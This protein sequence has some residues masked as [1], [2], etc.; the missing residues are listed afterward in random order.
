MVPPTP[1]CSQ[2]WAREKASATS[3][4]SP[5]SEPRFPPEIP[6]AQHRAKPVLWNTVAQYRV[7]KLFWPEVESNYTFY[8]GGSTEQ[9]EKAAGFRHPGHHHR[10]V[11]PAIPPIPNRVPASPLVPA[12]KSLPQRFRLH[13][14][15][16]AGYDRALDLL[17][18]T[19]PPQAE[20]TMPGS[21]PAFLF[22]HPQIK[23]IA[24]VLLYHLFF[25]MLQIRECYGYVNDQH[26]RLL[27]TC[28][29]VKY[30]STSATLKYG[31][32]RG[33]PRSCVPRPPAFDVRLHPYR[34]QPGPRVHAFKHA[35]VLCVRCVTERIH[36]STCI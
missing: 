31:T 11:R 35:G 12:C 25:T 3:T 26:Y 29:F 9:R 27:K 18:R 16:R 13:V 20:V 36:D 5:R 33:R 30:S 4:F 22:E 24:K 6:Q 14:Q 7:G 17:E 28:E 21:L 15:P 8:N 1:A 32:K 10:Q 23:C 2:T 34:K 19:S